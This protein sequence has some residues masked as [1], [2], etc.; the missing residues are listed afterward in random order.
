VPVPTPTPTSSVSLAWSAVAATSNP[1]TNAVG[2]RLKV[3]SSSG[4]YTQTVDVGN[5]TSGAVA[6]KSGSKYFFVVT[7]YNQAGIEGGGSNEVSATAP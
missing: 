3:G 4:N 7:A 5:S 1:N 2:Y 6:L